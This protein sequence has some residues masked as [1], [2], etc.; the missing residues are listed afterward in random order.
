[1]WVDMY[2]QIHRYSKLC[3]KIYSL[4]KFFKIIEE[5]LKYRNS[6]GTGLK[7]INTFIFSGL[8]FLNASRGLVCTLRI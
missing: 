2:T 3:I 7:A 1:M 5:I 6:E 8:G 4:I